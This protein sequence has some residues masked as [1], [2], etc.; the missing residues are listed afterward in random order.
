MHEVLIQVMQK[1]GW[2]V[3]EWRCVGIIP[4]WLDDVYGD[5]TSFPSLLQGG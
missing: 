4:S 1:K 3:L 2:K 5:V